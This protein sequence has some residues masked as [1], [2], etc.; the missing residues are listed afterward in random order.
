MYGTQF[1]KYDII[2]LFSTCLD[3]PTIMNNSTTRNGI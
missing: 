2:N 3:I 1:F